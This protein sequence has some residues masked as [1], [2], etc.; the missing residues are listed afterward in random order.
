M[1]VGGLLLGGGLSFL[2]AQYGLPC[3][4]VINYEVVLANGSIVDARSDSN[5]DLYLALRG[6]GNQFG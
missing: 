1:G 5:S 3:D 2:S 4:T 6:G